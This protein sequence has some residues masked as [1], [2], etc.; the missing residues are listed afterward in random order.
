MVV[1]V[2]G[3]DDSHFQYVI[4]GMSEEDWAKAKAIDEQRRLED[5]MLAESQSESKLE[6]GSKV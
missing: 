4:D 5:I 6:A 3:L 2:I 1:S